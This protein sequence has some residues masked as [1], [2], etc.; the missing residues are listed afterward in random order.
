MRPGFGYTAVLENNDPWEGCTR[1][2]ATD[3]FGHGVGY[4]RDYSVGTEAF[5]EMGK[6]TITHPASLAQIQRYFPKSYEIFKE[7]LVEIGGLK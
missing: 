1:G 4:W 6:A 5:A 7:M 3:H 2:R